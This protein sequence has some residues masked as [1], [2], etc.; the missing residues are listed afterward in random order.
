LVWLTAATAAQADSANAN[1]TAAEALFTEARRLMDAGEYDQACPKF[2]DSQRLD[3]AVGTLLNLGLCYK[4]SGKTASAWSAYREAAALA[5]AAAQP[6][7][8]ELAEAEAAELEAK[9]SKLVISVPKAAQLEHLEVRLDGSPVPRGLWEVAAP[10]DPGEH[11]VVVSA[12]HKQD[13][14]G[15]ITVADQAS[16]TLTVP[17]LEDAV[18]A[19]P[20]Q[21]DPVPTT[22]PTT[23]T[24]LDDSTSVGRDQGEPGPNTQKM[25][26]IVAGGVGLIGA[27]VGTVYG[28]GARSAQKDSESHCSARDICDDEGLELRDEASDRATISTV[29]FG[30]SLAGVAG[31]MLLWLTAPESDQESPPDSPVLEGSLTPGVGGLPWAVTVRGA[32]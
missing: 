9:L 10:V 25:L 20:I 22:A 4:Q 23:T 12:P 27:A 26:A 6:D 29:A 15:R 2:A 32:W 13:W 5:R 16:E 8:E 28:L 30:V 18:A 1:R 17:V 14:T 7:R 3:P 11:T 21:P 19:A 31:G 24:P